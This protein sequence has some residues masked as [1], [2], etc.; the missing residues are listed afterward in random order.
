MLKNQSNK[1]K[2]KQKTSSLFER[3]SCYPDVCCRLGAELP[4]ELHYYFLP[5]SETTVNL[6]CNSPGSEAAACLDLHSA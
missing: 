2:N 6:I 3:Q 5:H 1:Q 4:W